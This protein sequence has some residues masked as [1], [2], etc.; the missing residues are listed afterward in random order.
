[1]SSSGLRKLVDSNRI[2]YLKDGKKGRIR[3]HPQFIEDYI[4]KITHRIAP[5]P[6]PKPLKTKKPILTLPQGLGG[7]WGLVEF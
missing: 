6:T 7:N 1:M 2:D 5:A 3:F 4:E